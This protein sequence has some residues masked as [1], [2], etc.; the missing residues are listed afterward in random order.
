MI[1]YCIFLKDFTNT[2][3]ENQTIAHTVETSLKVVFLDQDIIFNVPPHPEAILFIELVAM[4]KD[5]KSTARCWSM[6]YLFD[7]QNLNEGCFKLPFYL[8]MIPPEQLKE[9]VPAISSTLLHI[10]ILN[11]GNE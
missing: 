2:I 5:K 7:N 6:H 4:T 11:P 1:K 8:N 3:F 9:P 10:K